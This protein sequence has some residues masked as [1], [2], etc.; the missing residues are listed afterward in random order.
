MVNI[1]L[2]ILERAVERFMLIIFSAWDMRLFLQDEML[3]SVDRLFTYL[4]SNSLS[5]SN[6][7]MIKFAI[8]AVNELMASWDTF[9][10]GCAFISKKGLRGYTEQW[11]PAIPETH[12]GSTIGLMQLQ[13]AFLDNSSLISNLLNNASVGTTLK[14]DLTAIAAVVLVK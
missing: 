7:T 13:A 12:S 4:R 8:A 10:Q 5:S 9:R 11:G 3:R 6:M 14:N 1:T 2:D